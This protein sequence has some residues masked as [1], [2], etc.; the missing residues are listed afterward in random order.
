M[1][2]LI[3]GSLVGGL[4]L[5]IWQF[6]SYST[7]D[8][9]YNQMAYTPNQDEIMSCLD[10]KISEGE[11]YMIRAPKGDMEGQA[12][13]ME[14]RLGQ[15]WAAIQYH[16]S[17]ENTFFSN[18][19]R[20]FVINTLSIFFLSWIMLKMVDLTMKDAIITSVMV[21]LIGYFT[22]NYLDTIWF[23]TDSI[24]DLLDAII[25]WALTGAWLGWWLRR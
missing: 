16:D 3:I 2:K 8:L 23:K 11:Y 21:G 10:G 25:P 12:R 9:H 13:V 7:F 19:G 4:I 15:P 1:Q 24:P 22:I 6:L 14:E 18:L 5:F 17:M 20:A